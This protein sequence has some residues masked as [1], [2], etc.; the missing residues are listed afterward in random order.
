[1]KESDI[2]PNTEHGMLSC[3]VCTVGTS[4]SG[5]GLHAL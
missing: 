5:A 1:M 3:W 2:D 4:L